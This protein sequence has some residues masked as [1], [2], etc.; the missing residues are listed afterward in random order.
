MMKQK[1][2]LNEHKVI[3][4]ESPGYGAKDSAWIWDIIDDDHIESTF[5]EEGK[6]QRLD[7]LLE[8]LGAKPTRLRV[9]LA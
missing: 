5:P 7:T 3:T 1:V 9:V 8:E 2:F 6:P 4:V